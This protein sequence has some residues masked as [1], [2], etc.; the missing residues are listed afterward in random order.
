MS[1]SVSVIPFD[2]PVRGGIEMSL[3]LISNKGT[4]HPLI[5]SLPT[6]CRNLKG[7]LTGGVAS[8]TRL[9]Q[10]I[11]FKPLAMEEAESPRRIIEPYWQ[12]GFAS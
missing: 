9:R 6:N 10:D 2:I 5:W 8:L 4:G 7:S 3:E 11:D 12:T 1:L